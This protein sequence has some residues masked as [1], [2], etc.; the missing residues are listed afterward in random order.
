VL[1]TLRGYAS[2]ARNPIHQLRPPFEMDLK[3]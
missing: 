2:F 3:R 1:L